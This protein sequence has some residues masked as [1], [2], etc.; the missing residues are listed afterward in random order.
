LCVASVAYSSRRSAGITH[1]GAKLERK[2][3][4]QNDDE[5][6]VDQ[7]DVLAALDEEADE[8]GEGG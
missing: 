2:E 3:R 8:D 7:A 5:P 6:A 1:P 4:H